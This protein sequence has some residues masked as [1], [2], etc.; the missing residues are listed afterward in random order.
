MAGDTGSGMCLKSTRV[1]AAPRRMSRLKFLFPCIVHYRYS[2]GK[3]YCRRRT[4][5][6]NLLIEPLEKR[7]I[8]NRSA[9][10]EI[11][12]ILTN[13]AGRK[14]ETTLA[15]SSRLPGDFR[16]CSN[17]CFVAYKEP[18]DSVCAQTR[19]TNRGTVC[20]APSV[21][22]RANGSAMQ[23]QNRPAWNQPP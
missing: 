12:I 14:H 17:A 4:M 22:W 1:I 8:L 7:V 5:V 2:E 13:Q 15:Q 23:N 20:S 18:F 11:K 3:S 10:I 21:L 9:A 16:R 19:P 6:I